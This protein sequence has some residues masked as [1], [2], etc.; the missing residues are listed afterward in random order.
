MLVIFEHETLRPILVNGIVRHGFLEHFM[1][2]IKE[3]QIAPALH[4]FQSSHIQIIVIRID[5]F[6]VGGCFDRYIL[7]EVAKL[8]K[9]ILA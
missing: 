5:V 9:N 3:S 8:A 7:H 6:A 2:S 1:E 4:I